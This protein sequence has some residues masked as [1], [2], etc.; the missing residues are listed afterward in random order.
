MKRRGGMT[1]RAFAAG[2]AGSVAAL[3]APGPVLAATEVRM[4]EDFGPGTEQRW[5]YFSDQVMGGVSD[6]GA[7]LGQDGD[8][9]FV[10]LQGAV[11]TANNGGF[12]QIRRR[13]SDPVPEGTTGL[14]LTVR[15]NGE[16]YFVHL[17]TRATMLP[18]QYYQAGFPTTAAWRTVQVPFTAFRASG[19]MLPGQVSAGSI[20]SIALVAYGRDHDADL[21]VASIAFY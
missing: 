20:R 6:G 8:A 5:S 19:R 21:S 18:W 1:R 13:L 17:R 7:S 9:R 14:A 15:G 16:E 10:R 4:F 3:A 2:L 12:I 11:S